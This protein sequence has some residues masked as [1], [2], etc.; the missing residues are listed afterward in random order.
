M[1]LESLS[2][3]IVD[4]LKEL[5]KEKLSTMLPNILQELAPT[6]TELAKEAIVEHISKSD[7]LEE[8]LFE[9]FSSAREEVDSFM[10]S[11]AKEIEEKL[12]KR[13]SA[14][15]KY[16]RHENFVNLYEECLTSDPIYVPKK[17]RYDKYHVM[18]V[19][20]LSY[21]KDMEIQ[22]LRSEIQILGSRRDEFAKRCMD[23]DHEFL[24][25]IH[26]SNVSN[27]A[28]KQ[29]QDR[30]HKLVK[31]DADRVNT[32]WESKTKSM[33][34]IFEKDK[35]FYE[36][37][38]QARITPRNSSAESNDSEG[39]NDRP[40]SST[41]SRQTDNGSPDPPTELTRDT[42]NVPSTSNA[43]LL[44]RITPANPPAVNVTRRA[45]SSPTPAN[46]D[47]FI[48]NETPTSS[49]G[50]PTVDDTVDEDVISPTPKNSI[51]RP[52]RSPNKIQSQHQK[53]P[54]KGK[55]YFLRS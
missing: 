36:K 42:N 35:K 46:E 44:T 55:N 1:A 9:S 2:S 10:D 27:K 17:F 3:E 18:S 5:I 7:M 53:H 4:S 11:F 22:R 12:S 26:N 49:S 16:A 52:A 19:N 51:G 24:E 33:K 37:N 21:I 29:L 41:A 15:Y 13:K 20:E 38:Q 43:S 34:D 6:I 28:S 48:I 54:L 30:W 45:N 8:K 40:T 32:D 25:M 31:K 14:Y 50:F 47:N 23:F 39:Q